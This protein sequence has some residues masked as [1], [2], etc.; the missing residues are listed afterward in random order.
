M[1]SVT[2]LSDGVYDK[3]IR[4]LQEVKLVHGPLAV[5]ST[6]KNH[7]KIKEFLLKKQKGYMMELEGN[8]LDL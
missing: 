2:S 7:P 6:L 3:L 8:C 1:T 5:S 4:L